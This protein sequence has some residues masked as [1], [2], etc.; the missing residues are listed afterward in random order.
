MSRWPMLSI[1]SDQLVFNA[2]R[3]IQKCRERNIT[4]TGVTKGL[5]G[6]PEFARILLN[7]GC[8]WLADSR[9]DNIYHLKKLF[10]GIPMMLIR[11]PMKSEIPSLVEY[12]DSSLVSM[13]EILPMI[14]RACVERKKTHEIMM[15]VDLGDLREGLME[16]DIH[17]FA[18][19]LRKCPHVMCTGIAVNFGCFGGVIPTP[20]KLE[21]LIR[22]GTQLS[23]ELGYE[24]SWYSGG[25]TSTLIRIEDGSLPAG[26]NHLRI[27]EAFLLGTDCTGQRDIPYL[28]QE[29]MI[30]ECEVVEIRTKPSVPFGTIG[31]DA[32][33]NIPSFEQRGRRKRAIV[34]IGKQD[35]RIEGIEPIAKGIEVLGASSDHLILDVES[36]EEPLILGDKI[37]FRVNYG[38]ML[39]LST[40]SYVN[41]EFVQKT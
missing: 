15:M 38:S 35:L 24:I 30:L 19:T 12:A 9:M 36:A 41:V 27:G 16:K 20:D 37:G 40:S 8:E 34:A 1:N 2:N 33:G 7:A 14:E 10:P 13:K 3:I 17:D 6:H 29:T 11:I 5:S 18:R 28:S 22:W 21:E 31:A 4:V 39:S 25:A 23:S 32:F 26:V